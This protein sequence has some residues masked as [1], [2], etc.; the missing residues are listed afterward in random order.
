M[1]WEVGEKPKM[2]CKQMVEMAFGWPWVVGI[3]EPEP[4]YVSASV[5]KPT[6]KH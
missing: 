6:A 5:R 1:I 4:L 2:M 3:L